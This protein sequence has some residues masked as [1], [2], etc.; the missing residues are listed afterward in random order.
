VGVGTPGTAVLVG[1]AE[2]GTT[3]SLVGIGAGVGATL[4]GV[5]V[6]VTVTTEIGGP[7]AAA[8]ATWKYLAGNPWD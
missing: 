1:S 6:M 7:V 2:L 3:V 8:A 5:A 4:E